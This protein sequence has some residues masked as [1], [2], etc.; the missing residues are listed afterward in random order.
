MTRVCTICFHPAR[1]AIE[2]AIV[3]GESYRHI[4]SQYDVGYKSVERHIAEHIRNSVEQAQEAVEEARGLDVVKQLKDINK[5]SLEILKEA[6]KLK[7][8]DMALKAIDRIAKQLELQ[9]K[10]LGDIDRPQVNV[11]LS[12]EWQDIRRA[13]IASLVPFPDARI[14]VASAL[15]TMEE[16]R[17]RLN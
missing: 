13:I 2:S 12:P 16:S 4:A 6:R 5:I 1:A 15:A 10:L 14:A 8:N 9:A 3:T 7:E 17:A 11:I